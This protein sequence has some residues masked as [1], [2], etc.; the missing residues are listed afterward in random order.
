MNISE[1][2]SKNCHERESIGDGRSRGTSAAY[3]RVCEGE[4]VRL[5]STAACIDER[6]SAARK[7]REHRLTPNYIRAVSYWT[8]S[9]NSHYLELSTPNGEIIKVLRASHP[10]ARR[11]RLTVTSHGARLTYPTGTRS[12]QVVD[13]LQRNANWL[14]QKLDQLHIAPIGAP[15]LTPGAATVISLRGETTQLCWQAGNFPHIEHSPQNNQLIIS[16]PKLHCSKTLNVVRAL[17]HS[18]LQAQIR[19]DLSHWLAHYT[20]KLGRAPTG[21]R[22]KPLKS[23][24]GSLDTRDRITLDLALALA[25]PAALEYVVVHELCHLHVRNHSPRFWALVS[26]LYPSWQEQRNWLRTCGHALKA[27]LVRLTGKE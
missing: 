27:E 13:F 12:A 20:P 5:G 21:I 16:M 15:P 3:K 2:L 10:R 24:W 8:A 22:I 1:N 26:S 6:P 11:L 4:E 7:G 14:E 19:R 18:F 25:P 17:L 9:D 23:L